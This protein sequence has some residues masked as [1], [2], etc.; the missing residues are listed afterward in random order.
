MFNL[1]ISRQRII[2]DYTILDPTCLAPPPIR[3]VLSKPIMRKK[4]Q[5]KTTDQGRFRDK[6]DKR[7]L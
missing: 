4:I 7:D 2:R 3:L 1:I 5:G 6:S